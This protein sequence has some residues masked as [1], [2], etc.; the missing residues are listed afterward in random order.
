MARIRILPEIADLLHEAVVAK[1]KTR[2]PKTKYDKLKFQ[3]TEMYPGKESI[4]ADT[5][6]AVIKA[7][8]NVKVFLEEN[9]I[10]LGTRRYYKDIFLRLNYNRQSI[11]T[12]PNLLDAYSVF[13]GK[14]NFIDFVSQ[15]SV[16]EDI[17]QQQLQLLE[18]PVKQ[19]PIELIK[20]TG[21]V[22]EK[23]D[24]PQHLYGIY[25]GYFL[26]PPSEGGKLSQLSVC[27]CEDNTV[28]VKTNRSH[29]VNEEKGYYDGECFLPNFSTLNLVFSISAPVM[30]D[31]SKGIIDSSINGQY[32]FIFVLD[33]SQRVDPN[34]FY[35]LKDAILKGIYAGSDPITKQPVAGRLFLKQVKGFDGSE[36]LDK[37]K[38]RFLKSSKYKV[39]D[40]E[41]EETNTKLTEKEVN[42]FFFHEKRYVENI[43]TIEHYA[44]P[45]GKYDS[46]VGD[47][48]I[49]SLHSSG[50][51]INRGIMRIDDFGKVVV[52]GSGGKKTIKHFDGNIKILSDGIAVIEIH[53]NDREKQGSEGEYIIYYLIK[54][55]EKKPK[56]VYFNGVKIMATTEG[57]RKPFSGRVV[58]AR[59]GNGFFTAD[60][61]LEKIELFPNTI[62]KLEVLNNFKQTHKGLFK[63]L[64]GFENNI[65]KSFQ[66]DR[67][68]DD[69][70][71][72]I[73][74]GEAFEILAKHYAFQS[75]VNSCALFLHYAQLHGNENILFLIEENE[76]Y[77]NVRNEILRHTETYSV[78][79][80]KFRKFDMDYIEFVKSAN[81]DLRKKRH[82]SRLTKE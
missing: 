65:V 49:Y 69:F 35:I 73:D 1:W 76:E 31:I 34:S 38:D 11:T 23:Y 42:D 40:L 17:K 9:K 77:D 74:Y 70:V 50:K 82:K 12:D 54:I 41:P 30:K 13:V 3:T 29:E 39:K 61:P 4:D 16:A 56:E 62:E 66:R 53:W 21:I 60:K 20:S 14:N 15:C 71:K 10:R 52:N 36:R 68:N 19:E 79:K 7:D 33:I 22:E 72:D 57:K 78:G 59:E 47:F 43:K 18:Q 37:I 24:V 63:F 8:V 25:E 58:L 64:I 55:D 67:I 26:R 6:T 46:I 48:S 81:F 2:I 51:Y 75:D 5:V 45:S 32:L 80:H 28:F 44:I 27:I